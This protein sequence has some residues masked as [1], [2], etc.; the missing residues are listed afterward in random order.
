MSILNDLNKALREMEKIK[1]S[2]AAHEQFCVNKGRESECEN[3]KG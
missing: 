3:L 1:Q 2:L